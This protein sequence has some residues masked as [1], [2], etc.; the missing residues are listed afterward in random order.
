MECK[1]E[2]YSSSQ[3]SSVKT[4]NLCNNSNVPEIVLTPADCGDSKAEKTP[5]AP[6]AAVPAKFPIP[7]VDSPPHTPPPRPQTATLKIFA[8]RT[9]DMSKGFLTF[10]DEEPGLTSKYIAFIFYVDITLCNTD[11]RR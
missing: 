7:F 2:I 10:S 6:A 4:E 8:P 5:A 11:L 3:L 1:D 9:E